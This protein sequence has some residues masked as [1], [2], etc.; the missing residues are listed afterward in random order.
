MLTSHTV[1]HSDQSTIFTVSRPL[2]GVEHTATPGHS[3]SAAFFWYL[4]VPIA[5]YELTC[6]HFLLYVQKK[7]M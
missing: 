5:I 1:R 2:L 3:V 6:P 7:N 4:T